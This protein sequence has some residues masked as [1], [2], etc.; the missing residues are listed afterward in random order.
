MHLRFLFAFAIIAG[1]LLTGEARA[2]QVPA[3][4]ERAE[5]LERVRSLPASARAAVLGRLRAPLEATPPMDD[6]AASDDLSLL[7][8]APSYSAKRFWYG[9]GS[10]AALDAVFMVGLASIWYDEAERTSFHF[11]SD[12]D[13][14]TGSG[15]GG[16][17]WLDDWH[18]YAQQDKFG[19]VWTSWQIARIVGGYGRWAGLS[20]K[21]AGLFG[22]IVGTAFQ[23]QIEVSDGFSTA[24]GFSRTDMLANLVGST[25]GGLKVAY[26]EGLEW[27]AAKYSYNPS[28][29]YGTQTTEVD[30]SGPLGYLGNAIKDYDGITYWITVRPEELLGGRAREAWPDWLA[31]SAG[32]GAD[33]IAHPIS[34]FSYPDS[35]PD[36]HD[37]QHRR[38]F[39]IA[40]DLD[41]LH[42]V[43][44][45]QPFQALARLFEFIRLPAPALQLAPEVEWHWVFY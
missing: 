36:D 31:F 4:P 38:E 2:Q 6:A 44:L 32:Y 34:G 26:P 1:L 13:N 9:T 16:D 25:I 10:A 37:Y 17:G 5:R 29:Y 21:K 20:P 27:F 8:P 3:S 18:T 19:H 41:F 24:Y 22:G 12:S 35:P 14:V 40:P 15:Q 43:E 28:P 7:E 42:T 45:P 11:Y 23:T 39:Y 33:G 30:G